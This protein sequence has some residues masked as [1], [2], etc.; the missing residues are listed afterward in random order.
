MRTA[1]FENLHNRNGR[2]DLHLSLSEEQS[3]IK[4]AA[5]VK[6]LRKSVSHHARV[7]LAEALCAKDV[8]EQLLLNAGSHPQ[9]E[10]EPRLHEVNSTFRQPLLRV[11][12][13]HWQ[14]STFQ[15]DLKR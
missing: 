15:L 13:C 6:H 14:R 9:E 2:C 3:R 5:P 12:H 4:P 7:D 8:E 10:V 11:P 1:T